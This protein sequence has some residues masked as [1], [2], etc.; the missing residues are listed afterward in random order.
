MP[1][2]YGYQSYPEPAVSGLLVCA[3]DKQ[4]NT[5][6]EQREYT[7]IMEPESTASRKNP[8][9]HDHVAQFRRTLRWSL[10]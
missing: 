1:D 4:E 6:K 5:D 2:D 3:H 8:K 7:F 9:G 10:S